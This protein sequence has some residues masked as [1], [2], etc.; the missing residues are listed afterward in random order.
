MKNNKQETPKGFYDESNRIIAEFM[1]AEPDKKTFFL[2]GK[3]VYFYHESWDWLM[4]VVREVII[5]YQVDEGIEIDYDE[6]QH[7]VMDNDIERAYDEV[8]GFIM[9]Y[10]NYTP[11][12]Q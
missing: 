2:K 11:D 10:T 1:G 7:R 12:E 6:L 3:E 8:V 9:R 4:P 5:R